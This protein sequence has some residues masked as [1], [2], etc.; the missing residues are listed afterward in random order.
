LYALPAYHL[1]GTENNQLLAINLSVDA[2]A[3]S[4]RQIIE[5]LLDPDVS[6]RVAVRRDLPPS[7]LVE[8]M[9]LVCRVLQ[10]TAQAQAKLKPLVGQFIIAISENPE[11]TWQAW[12]YRNFSDFMKRGM[13]ERFGV[14]TSEAWHC[15]RISKNLPMLTGGD[16]QEIGIAKLE[17]LARDEVSERVKELLPAARDKNITVQ[18]FKAKALTVDP[19][20]AESLEVRN[21]SVML[22]KSFYDTFTGWLEDPNVQR[23]CNTRSKAAILE[24]MFAHVA[25]EFIIGGQGVAE[26]AA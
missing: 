17:I 12:G 16:F 6:M 5:D 2:L 20:L 15:V 13:P 3:Q 8:Q 7:K 1:D 21:F 18:E 9:T 26:R 22:P 19:T 23:Y 11:Q 25:E 24:A 10:G 4:E 14:S